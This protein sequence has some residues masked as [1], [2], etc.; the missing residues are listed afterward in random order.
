MRSFL[1]IKFGKIDT[2]MSKNHKSPPFTITSEKAASIIF[3]K[4]DKTGVVMASYKILLSKLVII[5]FP[6]K[7]I[8][9][10]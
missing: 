1:I 9:K 3:K 5:L 10:F 8:N 7:F 4:L 2:K 6:Q